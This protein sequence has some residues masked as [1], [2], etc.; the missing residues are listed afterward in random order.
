MGFSISTGLVEG[1]GG[2]L[3]NDRMECSGMK[4]TKKGGQATLDARA[5]QM[6]G[7]W[8]DFVYIAV[9]KNQKRYYK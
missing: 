7:D 8:D 5:T 1:A 2:H 3:V 6:Q 9:Q 4:W